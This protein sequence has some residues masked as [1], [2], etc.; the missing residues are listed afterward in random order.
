[1]LRRL[2]TCRGT[3]PG[4]QWTNFCRCAIAGSARMDDHVE[5]LIGSWKNEVTHEEIVCRF[6]D[7][8][9]MFT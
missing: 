2:Q 8:V 1:M 3:S 4:Q 5:A 6:V 9:L 7:L